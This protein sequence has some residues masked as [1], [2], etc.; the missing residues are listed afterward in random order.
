MTFSVG[1]L[2]SVQEFLKFVK[3]TP[4]KTSE[5]VTLF[6]RFEATSPPLILELA[7]NSNWIKID[8]DSNVSVTSK[9][10][11]V[12]YEANMKDALRVQLKHLIGDFKPT[13]S[14]LIHKGR[15]EA[16][17]YFPSD[18]R[19]C[20][21]EAELIDSYEQDVVRWWDM[22]ASI[23]RGKQ[24]DSQLEIGRTGEQLSLEYEKRRIGKRAIW[25][26]VDSNLAGYDILSSVSTTDYTPLRIEVKAS[27]VKSNI[28]K[29]FLS[30]NEW[31]VAEASPNYL[32]HF[33]VLGKEPQLYILDK[34]DVAPSIPINQGNGVW[35][36]VK[37][38][39]DTEVLQIRNRKGK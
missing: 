13:W 14:Y 25:Q 38:E 22:F 12:V 3:E 7:E 20:F 17:Q 11:E 32:F 2:Y 39:I 27:T 5:F 28:F 23:A 18:V 37:V 6:K 16:Y 35:E 8:L 26:S 24:Q 36:N 19:Q 15:K 30:K 10:E 9:G 1:I 4:V 21:K 29:F 31:N 33:W 34:S